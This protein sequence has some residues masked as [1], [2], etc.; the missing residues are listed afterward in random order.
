MP[1]TPN[2]FGTRI[3]ISTFGESHG[4]VIGVLID[5]FPAGFPIDLEHIQQEL[6]RRRPGQSALSTPRTEEDRV[7]LVAGVSGGLTTGAP[8]ALQI[9]NRDTDSSKYDRFKVTPRPSHADYGALQRY[10]EAVDLRGSGRFSGRNTAAFVMAGALAAQVLK[11]LGVQVAAHTSQIGSTVDEGKYKIAEIR[12]AV[13]EG[14]V[15]CVSASLSLAMVDEITRT[16]EARDS[17]GGTITCVVE[18]LPAG[19]GNPMFHSLESDLA[20]AMFS[21]PAVKAIEFGAGFEAA[22]MRGS[23]HNDPWT[24]DEQGHVGTSSNHAGGIVGGIS[25]GMPIRFRVAIKP[26]ASIGI[27]QQTVNLLE[28]TTETLQVEGRHDPCIVPRAVPV[29]EAMTALVLLDHLAQVGRVGPT[30][31][32]N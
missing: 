20:A 6:N 26:T 18:G 25:T 31:A 22:H 16:K 2:S 23:Q 8:I 32:E 19:V 7:E 4:A 28:G 17:V 15:R 5:N 27:P 9:R 13:E 12:E 11:A 29:V 1:A 21:I 10:G 24:I 14:P 30:W 3:V